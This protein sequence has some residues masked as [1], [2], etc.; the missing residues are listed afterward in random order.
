MRISRKKATNRISVSRPIDELNI[1]C[2]SSSIILIRS[3]KLTQKI[4]N[5]WHSW[6][7]KFYKTGQNVKLGSFCE[8]WVFT[9]FWPLTLHSTCLF[10]KQVLESVLHHENCNL[11]KIFCPKMEDIPF[12]QSVFFNF[13]PSLSIFGYETCA[14]DRLGCHRN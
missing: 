2:I 5:V 1:V 3:L 14:Y 6:K 13:I 4:Q 8:N 12:L 11:K 7:S 10:H 9:W